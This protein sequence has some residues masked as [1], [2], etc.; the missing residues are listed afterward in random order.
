MQ[1]MPEQ[2]DARI[3]CAGLAWIAPSCRSRTSTCR[4]ARSAARRQPMRLLPTLTLV[5]FY[6]GTGLA[7]DLNPVLHAAEHAH[8]AYQLVGQFPERVQQ[9]LARLSCRFELIPIRN[10]VARPTN[11]APS[12]STGRRS[13]AAATEEADPH[14]STKCRIRAGTGAGTGRGGEEVARSG[15]KNVRPSCRK[16]RPWARDRASRL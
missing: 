3:D 13:S 8:R 7:G 9:H 2:A 15:G 11:T 4:T 5:G 16:S 1:E 6:G 14:R 10:R 12:W